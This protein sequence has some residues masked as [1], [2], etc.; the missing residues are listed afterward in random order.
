MRDRR[1]NNIVVIAVCA[2]L[3]VM[4][5]IYQFYSLKDGMSFQDYLKSY[6]V[7]YEQKE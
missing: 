7:M 6:G 2:V 1:M 4:G 3:T 5:I